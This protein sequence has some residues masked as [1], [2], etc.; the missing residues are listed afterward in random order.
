MPEIDGFVIEPKP[1]AYFGAGAIAGLPAILRAIGADQVVVV[2]DA[3]MAPTPVI[4]TVQA[5]TPA[6]C[7][8]PSSSTRS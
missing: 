5:G 3:A 7:R 8:P 6:R 2:T 1:P 4:A